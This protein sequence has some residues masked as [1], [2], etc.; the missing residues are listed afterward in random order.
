MNGCSDLRRR[1][2]RR[3]ADA[4][5]P[6]APWLALVTGSTVDDAADARSDIDMSLVFLALPP[7]AVLRAACQ[8][9]GGGP[10]HWQVG[11]F[12]GSGAVVAFRLEGV[13]TQI[14]Y[15]SRAIFEAEL[16]QVLLRHDPDTPLHKLCEGV[17]KAEALAGAD[18]LAQAQSRLAVFPEGLGRAM[19][20]HWLGQI[21]PW[22][23]VAQIVHRDALVWS[24]E[25][26]AQLAYRLIGALAG[27]NGR[28][29]TSFQ[30]KRMT[31]FVDRLRLKPAAFTARLEAA[32]LVEPGPGF[33]AL[34][35]L[36]AEVT[37]LVAARWPDLDLSAPRQRHAAFE[38]DPA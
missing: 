5:A 8:A 2:A 16:D 13:E 28:W 24:R 9:A 25:L 26:Q 11:A 30:F 38:P 14:A 33:A 29:F 12:D 21:T 36:E 7:E 15:G 1:L 22:R 3:V 23:T 27:L 34:H 35:A 20:V 6:L 19:A 17:A 4:H 10:W 37:A 31:P 32:L 18:A